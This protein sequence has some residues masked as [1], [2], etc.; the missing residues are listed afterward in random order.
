MADNRQSGHRKRL[1]DRFV[2]GETVP[3]DEMLLELLLTF[4]IPRRDVRPLAQE[5]LKA[6]GSLSQILSASPEDLNKVKGLGESSI[7]LLKVV[8]FIRLEAKP[9]EKRSP[10]PTKEEIAQLK[11]FESQRHSQEGADINRVPVTNIVVSPK[12]VTPPL[13]A[14]KAP[15]PKKI[16]QRKFQV[17]NGYLLEFEQLARVM[18]FLLEHRGEKKI[19]RKVL[20]EY[21][22]L[23]ERHVESLVSIG[24]AMGLIRS[25]VQ[26]LTPIGLLIAE[27]DIFLEKKGSLEWCHYVGAGSYR[28][29]IWFEIFNHQFKDT[30][31]MTH[32]ELTERIRMELSGKYSKRTI[33]KGLYEEVRFV[34]DAYMKRNFSK[35]WILNKL[36]DERLFRRRY[37]DFSLLVLAAMIYDFCTA[38]ESL[39]FQVSEMANMPGSPAVVFGLDEI[40]FRQQIEGIHDR[41][42]LRYETTHNLDQIRLKPGFSAMEFLAAYFENREPK[43]VPYQSDRRIS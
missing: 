27:H 2:A 8:N 1:R 3:S 40:S 21:T 16:T 37:T 20:Q 9:S 36:P 32:E 34:I 4:S 24:A 18:H 5:L 15:P 30:S 26:L 43:E 25:G 19:N 33:S 22:G 35:L 38:K 31:P 11:L 10:Q 12:P 29:L 13:K 42:W 23:A 7:A 6:F 14:K 39:L 17:S 41:G 28:N